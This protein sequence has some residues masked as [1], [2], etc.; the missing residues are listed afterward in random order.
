MRKELLE[1][2]KT[3]FAGV[4]DSILGRI[5]DKLAK[6]T[7]T[8]EQVK[9]AVDAYT[10]QQVIEGYG[11]SRAT[12]AQQTA[13]HTYEAKYG[14]KDGQKIDGGGSVREPAE[15]TT[16]IAG[17]GDQTPEWAKRL[18]DTNKQLTER[19]DRLEGER[20]TASRRTQLQAITGK[21]PAQ[22]R[23]PYERI[24]IDKMS[25]EEFSSLL[26]EVTT[27]VEG[28][29]KEVNTKGAVF[30]R[31]TAQGGKAAKENELTKEQ[32]EAISRRE[33]TPATGGQPF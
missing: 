27:E 10:L 19:L 4:S 16:H 3:K 29:A 12:E 23:K 17:G 30:G 11:D 31:P 2:L 13:V 15:N 25:N 24:S 32:Q 5:A 7:T 14:L 1:A 21:L 9:A 33:G 18:L 28:I 22:L 6:T 20:T 8:S 26:S